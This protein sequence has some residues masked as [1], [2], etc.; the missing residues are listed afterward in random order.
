MNSP[1]TLRTK[2]FLEVVAKKK[3]KVTGLELETKD[4]KKVGLTLAEAKD[5]HGQLDE[6]FGTTVE[7]RPSH[8]IYIDRYHPY[9]NQPW[10]TWC[11]SVS[12]GQDIGVGSSSIVP[13]NTV[14][15]SSGLKI[16]Y[17]SSQDTAGNPL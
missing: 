9:W 3:L 11:G 16:S 7:Y 1:K 12:G 13:C 8:P 5:L 4:G 10:I 17:L 14:G 2:R 6:L 15:Q